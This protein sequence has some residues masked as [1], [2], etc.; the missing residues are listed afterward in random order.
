MPSCAGT[1]MVT[2]CMLTF[3][4]R[5]RA[6][7]KDG[8]RSERTPVPA[9]PHPAA[10][11]LRGEGRRATRHRG[12]RLRAGAAAV[13]ALLARRPDLDAVFAASDLMASGALGVLKEAGLRVPDDVAVVGF[14]DSELARRTDPPLTTVFQPVEQMGRE[15]ARLLVDRIHGN[16]DGSASVLL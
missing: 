13:R 2:V 10:R 3:R 12:A 8:S 15:M 16:A 6:P 9:W 14:E 1:G 7:A 11:A 4:S 5:C